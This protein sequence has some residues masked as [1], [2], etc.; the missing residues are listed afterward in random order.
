MQPLE[1]ISSFLIDLH[2]SEQP[3]Y[4]RHTTQGQGMME[5][6]RFTFGGGE[7]QKAARGKQWCLG[8]ERS[9]RE[10]EDEAGGESLR[11]D[12]HWS[13]AAPTSKRALHA[14]AV[15]SAFPCINTHEMRDPEFRA[16]S[17][18]ALLGSIEVCLI[19]NPCSIAIRR[20]LPLLPTSF[21]AVT[22]VSSHPQDVMC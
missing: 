22:F 1:M 8:A 15:A 21:D 3:S 14:T 17:P 4:S 6:S 20:S 16:R 13:S 18:V 2:Q 11:N 10:Q 19:E 9:C 12:S 7:E 5:S